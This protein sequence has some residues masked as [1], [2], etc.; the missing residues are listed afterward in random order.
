MS[1]S[2]CEILT[3]YNDVP[4]ASSISDVDLYCRRATCFGDFAILNELLVTLVTSRGRKIDHVIYSASGSGY[5]HAA[6]RVNT[7][8]DE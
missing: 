7:L 1:I 8:L 5:E 4:V 3:E 6:G 2:F